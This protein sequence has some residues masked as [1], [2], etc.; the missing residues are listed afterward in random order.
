MLMSGRASAAFIAMRGEK[1]EGATIAR[2]KAGHHPLDL[3]DPKIIEASQTG[4]QIP[5]DWLARFS[6]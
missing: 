2:E 4:L 6:L 1:K 3:T 5:I